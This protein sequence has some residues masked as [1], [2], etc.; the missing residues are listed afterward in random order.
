MA[1]LSMVAVYAAENDEVDLTLAAPSQ[2]GATVGFVASAGT[3]DQTDATHATLTMPNEDVTIN[4]VY[5]VSTN[6]IAADGTSQSHAAKQLTSSDHELTS[7]WY[8]V[9][10]DVTINPYLDCNNNSTRRINV[11]GDVKLILA[12]GATLDVTH[13]ET[14]SVSGGIHVPAGSSLTTRLTKQPSVVDI[15]ASEGVML[16]L[17]PSP[18]M[19]ALSML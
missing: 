16:M 17:A 4:A 18:S 12:D 10:S 9:N 7:G 13:I 15:R 14:P 3:L 6:Y 5:L 11:S 8:V 2:P 1:S 19:E